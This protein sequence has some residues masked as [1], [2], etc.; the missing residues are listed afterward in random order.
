MIIWFLAIG[1]CGIAGIVE[2]PEILSA[3]SPTYAVSFLVGN[4]SIAFFA[5]AAWCWR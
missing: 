1:A 3:L 2:H 5:L 4:F